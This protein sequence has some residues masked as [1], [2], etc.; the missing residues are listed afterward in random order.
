MLPLPEAGARWGGGLPST[1]GRPGSCRAMHGSAS[2]ESAVL[3]AWLGFHT[4]VKVWAS[5]GTQPPSRPT[6]AS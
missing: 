4:A 1:A 3:G 2:K 6:C 5:R